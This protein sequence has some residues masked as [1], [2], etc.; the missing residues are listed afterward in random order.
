MNNLQNM[1]NTQPNANNKQQNVV[2]QLMSMNEE[3]RA[4]KIAEILNQKGIT[5]SQLE[6]LIKNARGKRL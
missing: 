5:K 1:L 3:E 4:G 6:N 2:M